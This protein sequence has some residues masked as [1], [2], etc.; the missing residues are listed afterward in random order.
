MTKRINRT[1]AIAT[2]L[3]LAALVCL[4][5]GMRLMAASDEA[6]IPIT[7]GSEAHYTGALAII[8]GLVVFLLGSIALLAARRFAVSGTGLLNA[9]TNDLNLVDVQQ[10][11]HD[12]EIIRDDMRRDVAIFKTDF[13]V[14]HQELEVPPSWQPEG[15]YVLTNSGLP[16]DPLASLKATRDQLL[17]A[18][19]RV[20]DIVQSINETTATRFPS[21]VSP[22]KDKPWYRPW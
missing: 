19:E 4:G 18:A 20:D 22:K 13:T 8:G 10:W 7:T 5:V 21:S 12:L 14:Q 17:T 1:F 3:A 11:G 2:L 16:A 9:A 15:H 6:V